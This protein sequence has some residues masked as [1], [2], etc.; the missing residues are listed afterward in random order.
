MRLE[1]FRLVM[2]RTK[3]PFILGRCTKC[4]DHYL[5]DTDIAERLPDEGIELAED[6]TLL[7][8]CARCSGWMN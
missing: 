1:R 6:G 5:F 3:G 8:E 4:G 2:L 7:G